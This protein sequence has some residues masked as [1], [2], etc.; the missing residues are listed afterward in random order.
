M[1][2]EQAFP[3]FTPEQDEL[4]SSYLVQAKIR[5]REFLAGYKKADRDEAESRVLKAIAK[6]A[7]KYNSKHKKKAKFSTYAETAVENAL[8]SY[9]RHLGAKYLQTS[10]A[11]G[12]QSLTT[13]TGGQLDTPGRDDDPADIV[14][15]HDDIVARIKAEPDPEKRKGYI[16][17]YEQAAKDM[18]PGEQEAAMSA[19]ASITGRRKTLTHGKIT[20]VDIPRPTNPKADSPP[21]SSGPAAA[22][23]M[24]APDL[25]PTAETAVDMTTAPIVADPVSSKRK[26]WQRS[27]EAGPSLIPRQRISAP[28]LHDRQPLYP[29]TVE[30]AAAAT[31]TT[32]ASPSIPA[33]DWGEQLFAPHQ[34]DVENRAANEAAHAE[35]LAKQSKTSGQPQA[36]NSQ[37]T[38]STPKLGRMPK[39]SDLGG[40]FAQAGAAFAGRKLGSMLGGAGLRLPREFRGPL[41]QAGSEAISSMFGGGE[42]AGGVPAFGEGDAAVSAEGGDGGT[43]DGGISAKF[44]RIIELLSQL[45]QA[46]GKGESPAGPQA[47]NAAGN[48]AQNLFRQAG[49]AAA[50]AASSTTADSNK[51]SSSDD[52]MNVL[53]QTLMRAAVTAVTRRP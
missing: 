14:A 39:G 29:K 2:R 18:P 49:T 44:D 11:G 41:M 45:L 28:D 46:S 21:Q 3:D 51:N 36:E 5:I 50:S 53:L 9:V 31:P 26:A 19:I 37:G 52:M 6:A 48:I 10:Q 32:F 4:F 20:A 12:A 42:A 35:Q 43:E 15:R 16:E 22:E 8:R 40:M 7:I 17:N 30:D 13:E 38:P 27:G 23:S 47:L 24:A 33:A 34:E 25:S 1:S